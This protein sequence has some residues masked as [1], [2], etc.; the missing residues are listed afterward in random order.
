M[1]E[2]QK[3]ISDIIFNQNHGCLSKE[4]L[5]RL[6]AFASAWDK[7]KDVKD[8]SATLFIDPQGIVK[9][10]KVELYYNN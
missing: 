6:K 10:I 5:G 2:T 4:E 9:K 7:I 3:P 8:G 1:P